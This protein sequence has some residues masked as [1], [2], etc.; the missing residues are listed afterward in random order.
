MAIRD[1]IQDEKLHLIIDNGDLDKLDQVLDKWSF[2]DYQSLIRFS[3]SLLLLTEDK[4]I[5]IKMKGS[6][7]EIRPASELLKE[8]AQHG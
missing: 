2:K 4:S 5:S 3:V 1:T 6:Q 8:E 7:T